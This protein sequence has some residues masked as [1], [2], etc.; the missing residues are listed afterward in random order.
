MA[1]SVVSATIE[2]WEDDPITAI[3]ESRPPSH[4]PVPRPVP[5]LD[6]PGLPVGV[7]GNAPPA[8]V[9]KVGTPEFRYWVLAEAMARGARFWQGCLPAGTTWQP[10]NGPRLIAVPDEGLDL[11]A[12]Y[13]RHG[14]HFFHDTVRGTPVYSGES[15]DVVCHELG[16]AVLDSIKPQLWDAASIEAA[17]FHESFGDISAILSALQLPE[18]R[19]R[20]LD[21]TGGLVTTAS[22]LSRLAED[23]GW[24]IRQLIPGSG[25]AGCLRSAVNSFY[26]QAPAT[27][28]PR[29]PATSLSSEPHNFSRIFTAGFFRM[30][31]G[32]FALQPRQDADALLTASRIAGKLLAEGVRQAPVV[33]GFYAQVA[34]SMLL[35]DVT[36]FQGRYRRA[37]RSGFVTTGVLSVTSAVAAPPTARVVDVLPGFDDPHEE[38]P[39]LPLS[40]APYGL[41]TDLLVRGAAH[42]RRFNAAG[43]V[44]DSGSSQ[45]PAPDKAA[46]SFVEDLVRRGRIDASEDLVGDA[47]IVPAAY[48]THEIRPL[49]GLLELSR[50]RFDC[51]FGDGR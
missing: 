6:V 13:D 15:P 5:D 4:T 42:P 12:Y 11:N 27:L 29:A 44:P 3:E 33:T 48:T 30:L 43:G 24:A 2:A 50:T 31:G 34:A 21:D 25:D 39:R 40:G 22:R 18:L 26:Y 41:G 20:V 35:A 49:D 8:D 14:L 7:A 37:I 28:P 51:G 32:V 36:Q 46:D 38:L 19:Q 16:H 45:P 1:D 23:L 9:Y 17:A 47:P 10:D